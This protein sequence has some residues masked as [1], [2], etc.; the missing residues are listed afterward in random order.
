[1]LTKVIGS[2][3]GQIPLSSYFDNSPVNAGEFVVPLGK[4]ESKT[5]SVSMRNAAHSFSEWLGFI[6]EESLF[7]QFATGETSCSL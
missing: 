3:F 4:P 7:M 6:S 1:M 2:R 5:I